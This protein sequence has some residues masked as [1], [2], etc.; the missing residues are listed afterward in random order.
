M[1]L[2]SATRPV[3]IMFL[4]PV[5]INFVRIKQFKA[6]A[7]CFGYYSSGL[8]VYMAFLQYRAG[9]FWH[10]NISKRLGRKGW[11]TAHLGKQLW[12][13]AT[14]F[15]NSVLFL[16]SFLLSIYMLIKSIMKKLALI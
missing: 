14:D 15:H 12:V 9:D 11:D 1:G 7:Y 5:F 10:F 6:Y 2:L 13:M 3:G 4:V 16:I 8:V